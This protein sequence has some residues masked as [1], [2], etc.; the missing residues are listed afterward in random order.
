[1]SEQA[2]V[3]RGLAFITLAKLYFIGT[4]F[5]VQVGLPRL[6]GSPEAFGQYSLAMS[7]ANV[8]DNVLIASTV[9]SVAKR[10]SE[11]E[12]L[13]GAR[14]RQALGIQLVLGTLIALALFLLS[15]ALS[16]VAYDPA[17][18]GMLRIAATVPFCYALYAALV[19]SLNGRRMFKKQASL[20]ITFSTVR[21]IGILGAA[22]LGFGAEGALCGWAGAAAVIL[23]IALVVVGAG[24]RG[25]RLPLHSWFGFL[26]PIVLFQIALNGM[27]L[28]DVWVL[29]NTTAELGLELGSAIE[30]VREQASALVGYYRS[31]Q[32]FALV[33]Y[34]VLLSVTFVVFPLVSRA[35]AA[36]DAELAKKHIG[37]A[38]RFSVLMLLALSSPIAGGAEALVR[39]AYGAKFLPAAPMLSVLVLGQVSLALFVIVA[40]ILSGAGK[41]FASALI[42][43]IALPIML[44]GSRLA[45]RAVGLSDATLVA[46]AAATSF[47]SLCA[48]AL[49]AFALYRV[50][51][52][53]L[54]YRSVARALVAAVCGFGAARAVPQT[55]GLFAP[56]AL[57]VGFFSYGLVLVV[58]R[59]LGPSELRPLLA[60][61][62]KK[63]PPP[64]VS[65]HGAAPRG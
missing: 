52:V 62:R 23:A 26:L 45:V 35:T 9:Q 34:Q 64:P 49:S 16:G 65:P 55:S 38:L 1:M 4:S 17:L 42:G 44:V 7:L 36:G 10:V 13:G 22:G 32:N 47:G 59:E 27:L 43:G 60:R 21:T 53:H 48:L 3:G 50:F 58:L 51:G 33:P 46:A 24:E 2:G 18:T 57:A 5:V 61:F 14:L 56:V 40:T 11:N 15:P 31:A 30:A 54:P 28:L 37:D 63:A 6:L 29:K 20:D 41:P 25:E 12:A 19:G 8:V 39:L